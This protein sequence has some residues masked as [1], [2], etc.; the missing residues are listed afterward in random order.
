MFGKEFFNPFTVGFI[1]ERLSICV[2]SLLFAFES[3]M[4]DLIEEIPDHCLS[5]HFLRFY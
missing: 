3:G 4:W 2:C 1:H 5:I